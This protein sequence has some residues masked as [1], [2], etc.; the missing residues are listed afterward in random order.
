M[1]QRLRPCVSEPVI[2]VFSRRQVEERDLSEPLEFLRR[3]TASREVALEFSGR[4]SLVVDGY[5]DDPRELFEIPEVRSFLQRLDLEWPHWFFFLSQAD[6]SIQCLESCLADTIEIAPGVVSID[7][8]QMEGNLAR[9][10]TAMHRLREQLGLPEDT[11][12]EIAE[13]VISLIRNASVE[14]IDGDEY[15]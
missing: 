7:V 13:G 9:H 11:C 3:L 14:R 1:T 12:E 8:D 6:P 5:N 15:R 2:L 10:F 4:I